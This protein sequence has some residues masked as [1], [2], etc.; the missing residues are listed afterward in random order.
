MLT[1]PSKLLE[2]SSRRSTIIP[3]EN[4]AGG[5]RFGVA[6]DGAGLEIHD[7]RRQRQIRCSKSRIGT[8]CCKSG[9][10][11]CNK[12]AITRMLVIYLSARLI[13]WRGTKFLLPGYKR[14][15]LGLSEDW[16]FEKVDWVQH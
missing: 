10:R 4:I 5:S 15:R 14:R 8:T 11:E 1:E 2:N 6:S 9:S 13:R 3:L 16:T 12:F 7:D